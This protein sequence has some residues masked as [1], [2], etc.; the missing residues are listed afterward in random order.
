MAERKLDDI[1]KRFIL[2]RLAAHE[3]PQSVVDAL[4]AEFK[5]S[6]SRQ[7]VQCYDPD[8]FSG[9]NLAEEYRTYFH[10]C[11]THYER[12]MKR[13]TMRSFVFRLDKLRRLLDKAMPENDDDAVNINQALQVLQ[14]ARDEDVHLQKTRSGA[15]A[16]SKVDVT[17]GGQALGVSSDPRQMSREQ[18]VTAILTG[19]AEGRIPVNEHLYG[20]SDDDPRLVAARA[21][22]AQ[23]PRG[24]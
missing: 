22:A 9:R 23:L 4:E 5:V 24:T 19:I 2:E 20:I 15:Y 14:Q 3:K 17:S 10:E 7:A 6:I 18:L 13:H 12:A 11:R 16:A 1:H 8:T 21:A